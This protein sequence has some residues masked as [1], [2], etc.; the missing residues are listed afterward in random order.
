MK[1]MQIVGDPVGGIRKHV[2]S[3][4]LNAPAHGVEQ[5][6]VFSNTNCDKQF[7]KEITQ[8]STK[9]NGKVFSL[10]IE[11]KPHSSDL[12]NICRLIHIARKEKVDIIH[13]HGAKG[14]LYARVVSLFCKAKSLYTPHGGSAHN[15]FSP[16][17]EKLYTLVEKSLYS[18]TDLYVFESIY[19]SKALFEKIGKDKGDKFI[20]NYNGVPTPA[21]ALLVEPKASKSTTN[22]GVFAMLRQQKGQVNAILALEHL[23]K[24]N[25]LANVK[26]FIFGQ[27]EDSEMLEQVVHDLNLQPYVEFC[28]EVAFPEQFMAEMDIV[29]IPS[30]FESFGYVAIEA[31]S[32][33]KS[34]IASRVGGLVEVVDEEVGFLVNIQD[35]SEVARTILYCI[36][37]PEV[38]GSKGQAAKRKYEQ[39]FTEQKMVDNLYDIYRSALEKDVQEKVEVQDSVYVGLKSRRNSE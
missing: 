7:V 11:K 18:V 4:L 19:T 30:L 37:H 8:I 25:P 14:G 5:L 34:V 26:L 27:G 10:R 1:I 38:L 33:S 17:K 12:F 15:M 32:L 20:I 2:H 22:I 6:Y 31:F 13:G 39:L 36:E 23:L 3:I 29:L 16:I 24:L 28:G 35:Y 9:L 21:P